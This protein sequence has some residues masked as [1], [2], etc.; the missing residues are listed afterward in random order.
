[1]RDKQ[2]YGFDLIPPVRTVNVQPTCP[3]CGGQ[4]SP[5]DAQVRGKFVFCAIH[6]PERFTGKVFADL[7]IK[8]KNNL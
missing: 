5:Q 3:V 2:L 8:V 1:M 6:D 7:H 4:P